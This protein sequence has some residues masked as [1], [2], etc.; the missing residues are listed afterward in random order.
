MSLTDPI[1]EQIK[2]LYELGDGG[3]YELIK[4]TVFI[5]ENAL[6]MGKSS[7]F[8]VDSMMDKGVKPLENGIA[9]AVALARVN[10]SHLSGIDSSIRIKILRE[11]KKMLEDWAKLEAQNE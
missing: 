8:L 7:K 11:N 9:I 1:R 10:P 3:Q 4:R 5:F 6:I 2:V